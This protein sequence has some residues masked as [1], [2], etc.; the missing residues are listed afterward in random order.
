[1]TFRSA[2]CRRVDSPFPAGILLLLPILLLSP[3]QL[4]A[5]AETYVTE[6]RLPRNLYTGG[7]ILLGKGLFDLEVRL[8]NEHYSLAFLQD[9]EM[10][11]LV[12]GQQDASQSTERV[13]PLV[14]THYLRSTA[15]PLGTAEERQLSKTGRPQ[16]QDD[17]REWDSSLRVFRGSDDEVHFIFQKR[18]DW[19]HWESTA[20]K[21]FLSNPVKRR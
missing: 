9:E 19:G 18:K 5:E 21:L 15:I 20:F 12:N 14:G 16:Y 1:M 4:R 13:I 7:G 3:A 6:I 17:D 2:S 10:V 11:A 8:E